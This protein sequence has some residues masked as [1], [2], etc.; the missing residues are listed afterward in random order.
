M[1]EYFSNWLKWLSL[2]LQF[3]LLSS[4]K[5]FICIN[6]SQGS[7]ATCWR[8][9]VIFHYQSTTD[10]LLSLPVE[11]FW[12]SVSIWQS[13][14]Q[15][16]S[17]TFH[18]TVHM[19]DSWNII[20]YMYMQHSISRLHWGWRWDSHL[21]WVAGN[22]LACEFP[23]AVRLSCWQLLYTVYVTYFTLLT[24]VCSTKV[25]WARWWIAMNN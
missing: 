18:D 14:G 12:K 17:G 9:D 6:M 22:T 2:T 20:H 19:P 24:S 16:Y 1:D 21:C 11:E 4:A 15:K 25:Q 10:S 8:M 3:A 13:Y 7:A 5:K 23:V